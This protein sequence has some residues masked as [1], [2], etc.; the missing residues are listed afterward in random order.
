MTTR[1]CIIFQGKLTDEEYYLYKND[2][3]I[4]SV[5]YKTLSSIY[6]I[7]IVNVSFDSC[8]KTLV[9]IKVDIDIQNDDNN[10]KVILQCIS[11]GKERII[12]IFKF[13]PSVDYKT[14]ISSNGIINKCYRYEILNKDIC[15]SPSLFRLKI[16]LTRTIKSLFPKYDKNAT[17]NVNLITGECSE[18]YNGNLSMNGCMACLEVYDNSNIFDTL[19]NARNVKVV[20]D[21]GCNEKLLFCFQMCLLYVGG[22]IQPIKFYGIKM[23]SD[24]YCYKFTID[25]PCTTQQPYI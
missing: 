21:D 15:V 10:T 22:T 20:I 12:H 25:E 24:N 7:N 2:E 13:N 8:N 3:T 16:P 5:S 23:K 4:L 6:E 19:S 9:T 17:I 14:N 11:P 1:F 18:I